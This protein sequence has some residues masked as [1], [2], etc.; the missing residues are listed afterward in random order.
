MLIV[1]ENVET[2][3]ESKSSSRKGVC[4]G[5]EFSGVTTDAYL[6]EAQHLIALRHVFDYVIHL[7]KDALPHYLSKRLRRHLPR[8]LRF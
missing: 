8:A 7:M 5:G 2:L 4:G 6:L 3:A 1:F